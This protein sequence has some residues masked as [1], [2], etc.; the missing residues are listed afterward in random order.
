MAGGHSFELTLYIGRRHR[1]L[2]CRRHL[3]STSYSAHTHTHT[4]TSSKKSGCGRTISVTRLTGLF[5]KQRTS[6]I[7][8]TREQKARIHNQ[9]KPGQA[10]STFGAET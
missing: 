1:K 6:K 2:R 10:A 8:I 9:F 4:H 7:N 3:P 5:L